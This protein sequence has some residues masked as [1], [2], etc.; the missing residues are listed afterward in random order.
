[1]GKNLGLLLS[2]YDNFMLIDDLNAQ[3]TEAT[4]SNFCEIYNLKHL[5]QVKNA[6]KIQGYQ[7]FTR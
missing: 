7:I 4:I 6:F 1:M 2:K 5:I 3:P